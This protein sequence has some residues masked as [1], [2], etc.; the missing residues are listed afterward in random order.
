MCAI[1]LGIAL[2][3]EHLYEPTVLI[4][5]FETILFIGSG[6]LS[7]LISYR[8]LIKQCKKYWSLKKVIT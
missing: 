7:S 5:N 4:R 1:F 8:K 3:L 6:I 2:H